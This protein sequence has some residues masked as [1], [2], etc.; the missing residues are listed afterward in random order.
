MSGFIL[1]FAH[2]YFALTDEGGRYRL[3]RV[4]PGEYRLVVWHEGREREV[5]SVRV[6]E[7]ETVVADFMVK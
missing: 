3:E 2:P 1:V 4:P 7:G 6:G 5:R